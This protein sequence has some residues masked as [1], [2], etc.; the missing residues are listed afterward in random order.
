MTPKTVEQK[1]MREFWID[2]GLARN[3]N[4]SPIMVCF[5]DLNPPKDGHFIEYSAFEELKKRLEDAEM[6][7]KSLIVPLNTAKKDYSFMETLLSFENSKDEA[8]RDCRYRMTFRKPMFNAL[9]SARE[10]QKRWGLK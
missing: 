5:D 2:N 8:I 1:A 10:Y 6:V 7:I 9:D 4:G 3:E